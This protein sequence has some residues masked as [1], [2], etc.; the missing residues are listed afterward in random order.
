MTQGYKQANSNRSWSWFSSAGPS[1]FSVNL[2]SIPWPSLA[3]TRTSAFFNLS[4]LVKFTHFGFPHPMSASYHW[5]MH[6]TGA[7]VEPPYHSL[8]FPKLLGS[9]GDSLKPP[10]PLEASKLRASCSREPSSERKQTLSAP[11]YC[12][13]RSSLTRTR[14]KVPTKFS[15]SKRNHPFVQIHCLRHH[16]W[17]RRGPLTPP[18]HLWCALPKKSR[19]SFCLFHVLYEPMA[20]ALS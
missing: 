4:A 6:Q 8:P 11:T 2:A 10:H 15:S 20:S 13:P 3:S 17:P 7:L 1:S 14:H 18:C 5:S 12:V 16:R 9:L 19:D